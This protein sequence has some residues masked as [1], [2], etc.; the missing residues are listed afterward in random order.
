MTAKHARIR[1]DYA[2]RCTPIGSAET[3]IAQRRAYYSAFK[4][5]GDRLERRKRV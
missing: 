2:A 3:R 5:S 4:P 1:D